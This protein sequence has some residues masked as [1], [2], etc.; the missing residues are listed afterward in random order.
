MKKILIIALIP[1][2]VIIIFF[3]FLFVI[4]VGTVTG[5]NSKEETIIT[6]YE[7]AS[8]VRNNYAY[9][10]LYK[11][12]LNKHLLDGYVSLE[13][14]VFYLQY[15]NNVLD[16]SSLSINKW[17]EAY[18]ANLNLEQGQMIPIKQVCDTLD[19]EN[20]IS[21]FSVQSNN[22]YDV[23]DLCSNTENMDNHYKELPYKFPLNDNFTVTSFVN[24]ERVIG[25][26]RDVHNGWDL[27]VATGTD[28]Y[29][30][31]SGSIN[32][33]VNTQMNDLPY[34]YSKNSVGNYITVKCDD[35]LTAIYYH[36]KYKSSPKGLTEGTKVSA[37]DMLGKTSTTG[38]STGPHLH[39][40]LEDA[41]RNLLDAMNYIDFVNS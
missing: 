34:K 16:V 39:V 7:T 8:M 23:I 11:Q 38:Y 18:L 13:R 4:I 12:I 41:N 25:N 27:A 29:S 14:I 30:I 19:K 1:I 36:I 17:E 26:T 15:T 9:A 35:G 21:N 6:N 22:K 20:F 32:K 37:G 24:E 28:F 40:Q 31:C 5:F 2:L 10:S 33:I 3:L